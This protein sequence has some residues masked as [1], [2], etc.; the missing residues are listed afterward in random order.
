MKFI[1]LEYWLAVIGENGYAWGV[2]VGV[3]VIA[4]IIMLPMLL[5]GLFKRRNNSRI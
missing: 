1:E 4:V 5:E 3:C 2:G